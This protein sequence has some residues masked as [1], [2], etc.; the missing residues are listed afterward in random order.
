[1]SYV[2]KVIFDLL[3]SYQPV[4]CRACKIELKHI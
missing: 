1:L 4:L 3:E 2:Y